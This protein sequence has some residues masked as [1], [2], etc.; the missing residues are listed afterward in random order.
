MKTVCI[1]VGGTSVKAALVG[2]GDRKDIRQYK[3]LSFCNF[4][5]NPLRNFDKL[6]E[7][8]AGAIKKY[9]LEADSN[10]A[11]IATAG[12]VDWNSGTVINANFLN[13]L[14][15]YSMAHDMT[16]LTGCRTVV[17]NDACA[18]AVGEHYYSGKNGSTLVLTIGTGL[19]SAVASGH[20]I[21][22]E[23][24][25]DLRLGHERMYE[26]GRACA[27]GQ[28]GCVEQY[29]SATAIKKAGGRNTVK[30]VLTD[31]DDKKC[32]KSKL[33]FLSNT[34][35]LLTAVKQLYKVDEILIGGGLAEMKNL[36]L[37]EFYDK[38]GH[39][40]VKVARLGNKAGLI[41][42]AYASLNGKFGNQ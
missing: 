33:D 23:H 1:D 30:E 7:A 17:I 10:V 35:K 42:V 38:Y 32:V 22:S 12:T 39:R 3:I 6:R 31:T 11:G 25:A 19:G 2:T 29:V 15:G 18:A 36:W 8:I 14:N 5:T 16:S 37:P 40:D 34:D 28:R 27:C 4:A 41:G 13:E 24:V 9:A 21:D 20:M 26:N